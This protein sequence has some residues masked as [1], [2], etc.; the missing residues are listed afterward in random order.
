MH[1]TGH[2]FDYWV[3]LLTD[4]RYCNSIVTGEPQMILLVNGE[5]LGYKNEI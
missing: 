5:P 3:I 1:L 4:K 2:Q